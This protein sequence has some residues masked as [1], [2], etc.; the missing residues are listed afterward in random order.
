MAQ[1]LCHV[2]A[3]L[4]RVSARGKGVALRALGGQ[5]WGAAVGVSGK[6]LGG[7]LLALLWIAGGGAEARARG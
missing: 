2:W 6:Q 3:P 4:P 1:K 7:R 5:L